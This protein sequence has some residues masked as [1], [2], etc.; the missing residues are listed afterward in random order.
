MK[1]HRFFT[2]TEV[3]EGAMLNLSNPDIT[4]SKL[5][6]K[7]FYATINHSSN[8]LHNMLLP[9]PPVTTLPFRQ[10][11]IGTTEFFVSDTNPR[12]LYKSPA[13]CSLQYPVT[14][15]TQPQI[16]YHLHLNRAVPTTLPR[17]TAHQKTVTLLPKASSL[18]IHVTNW[19]R[20]S[21]HANIQAWTKCTILLKLCSVNDMVTIIEKL[22]RTLQPMNQQQVAVALITGTW[23]AGF[24]PHQR[25]L[26]IN[27]GEIRVGFDYWWNVLSND[28]YNF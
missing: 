12:R 24:S 3:L 10:N 5:V 16:Y 22:G 27:G 20:L 13:M 9:T 17:M 25:N 7:D 21:T 1:L 4:S 18:K 28:Y 8:I 2:S 23:R 26:L 14:S 15:N 6:C 19:S 11:A